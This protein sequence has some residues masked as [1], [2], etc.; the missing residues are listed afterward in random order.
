MPK[1]FINILI[2]IKFSRPKI[3]INFQR[4]EHSCKFYTKRQ[5]ID[6]QRDE[7]IR[8][9]KSSLT[10]S[11]GSSQFSLTH[12][13]NQFDRLIYLMYQYKRKIKEEGDEIED[14]LP[15][16]ISGNSDIVRLQNTDLYQIK[17]VPVDE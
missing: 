3:F 16:E 10:N 8:N 17:T 15:I 11:V 13:I 4:R 5:H 6:I 12:L 2:L 9:L 1:V 14:K 7:L